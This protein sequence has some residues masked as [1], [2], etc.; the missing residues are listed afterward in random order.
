M[1]RTGVLF[2]L[3]LFFSFRL[4]ALEENWIDNYIEKAEAYYQATCAKSDSGCE[5]PI[6]PVAIEA[7]QIIEPGPEQ[8]IYYG[9]SLPWLQSTTDDFE[10]VPPKEQSVLPGDLRQKAKDI[11]QKNI[12]K[13]LNRE[14]SSS[15]HLME[16]NYPIFTI[17]EIPGVI[18]KLE[19]PK[20]HNI[21]TIRQSSLERLNNAHLARDI[22]KHYRL[23]YLTVPKKEGFI[24]FTK[25]SMYY[26]AKEETLPVL[27]V[28]EEKL[29]IGGD[30]AFQ[31]ELYEGVYDRFPEHP[32]LKRYFQ[33]MARQ[34]AV[35]IS[36]TGLWDV[37][38][39]NTP[40]EINGKGIAL[41][42][43]D[44]LHRPAYGLDRW[45]T[46]VAFPEF[47]ETIIAQAGE[48]Q[49]GNKAFE[50][51]TSSLEG[52][53]QTRA[54]EL[55]QRSEARAWEKAKG[56]KAG[57]PVNLMSLLSRHPDLNTQQLNE[58]ERRINIDL[59]NQRDLPTRL[60][61]QVYIFL[62][63]PPAFILQPSQKDWSWEENQRRIASLDAILKVMKEEGIIFSYTFSWVRPSPEFIVQ[64]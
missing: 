48:V 41:V 28:A 36:V 57:D 38:Y 21:E 4:M 35:F 13:I 30:Y 54:E 44:S 63:D 55:G 25:H 42:D 37:K 58:L 15:I 53:R 64:L 7:M 46:M 11:I 56:V 50:G 22:I 20:I 17:D 10:M 62:M 39:N 33:E 9:G 51:L 19:N 23:N 49:A 60:A 61:R 47:Y 34:L 31:Q 8:G 27:V 14:D 12:K 5:K 29:P 59:A 1:S 16:S 2:S 40:L 45:M 6:V 52:K 24:V 3:V 32:V 43:L 26:G 18:F